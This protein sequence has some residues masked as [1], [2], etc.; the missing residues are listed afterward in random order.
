MTEKASE[1][2]VLSSGPVEYRLERQTQRTVVVFHGGHMHAGV[3]L[4]EKPFVEAGYSVLVPSRPGYGRT[5]I[6]AGPIPGEF[7]D[8][9][10]DLVQ[11]LGLGEVSAVVGISAGGRYAVPMAVRHPET[12]KRLILQSSVSALPWPDTR[13]R[14]AAK[15][16]FNPITQGATWGATRLL[17]RLAPNRGLSMMLGELSTKPGR[18]VFDAIDVE[19]RAE[20]IQIFGSMRSGRGFVNDLATSLSP[21]VVRSVSQPTLVMA[22]R[23][24]GSVP[25]EHAEQLTQLIPNAQLF[26]SEAPS[27]LLWYGGFD[28]EIDDAIHDFLA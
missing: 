15:V 20:L 18:Q 3:A 26:V 9:V 27:H 11:H 4:G 13:T 2:A 16:V 17:F 6:A 22:S 21:E 23:S 1:V 10:L 5:P 7:A 24:D 19:Q 25:F 28:K 8:S 14:I 12:V